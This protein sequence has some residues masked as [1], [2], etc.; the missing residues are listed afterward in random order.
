MNLPPSTDTDLWIN[1]EEY[2]RLIERL[3]HVVRFCMR[4]DQQTLHDMGNDIA[5]KGMGW[6][7]SKSDVGR[8]RARKIFVDDGNQ[9]IRSMFLQGRTGGNLVTRHANIHRN[10]Y[11][12]SIVLQPW[13]KC[14]RSEF[15]F[16]Q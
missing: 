13:F 1:W 11:S 16:S 5:G 10:F 14:S 15:P 6:S 3:V 4:L 2:N 7:F 8:K 12:C 9:A